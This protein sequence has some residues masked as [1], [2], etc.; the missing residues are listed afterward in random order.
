MLFRRHKW[1]IILPRYVAECD[2]C[3]PNDTLGQRPLLPL[4]TVFSRVF[5]VFRVSRVF[6]RIQAALAYPP[7]RNVTE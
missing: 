6:R 3:L 4:E 1:R 2:D 5:R 7:D